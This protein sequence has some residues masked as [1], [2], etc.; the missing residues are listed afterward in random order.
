MCLF[1][2]EDKKYISLKIYII[3]IKYIYANLVLYKRM[4]S[5]TAVSIENDSTKNRSDMDLEKQ[6]KERAERN[7]QRALLL[8]KSKIVTHPY[9]R[10]MSSIYIKGRIITSEYNEIILSFQSSTLFEN[11]KIKFLSLKICLNNILIVI[12]NVVAV[13][14]TMS[15][16]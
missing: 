4:A 13:E 6:L 12:N 3:D 10:Y 5:T 15:L 16:Q 8:K 2:G 14:K 7:R 1:L 9:T 11:F